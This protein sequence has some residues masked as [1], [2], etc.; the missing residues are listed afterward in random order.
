[1]DIAAM[2]VILSQT[3]IQQQANISVMKTAMDTGERQMNDLIQMLE[4]NTK[5]MELSVQ[6]FLGK[7]IDIM[8]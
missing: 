7:N 4:Q 3:K 1:M 6:P 5:L 2:S 8:I